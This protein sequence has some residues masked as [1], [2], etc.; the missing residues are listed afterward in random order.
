[1]NPHLLVDELLAV[2]AASRDGVIVGVRAVTR[3]MAWCESQRVQLVASLESFT[4]APELVFAEAAR[5]DARSAVQL[6]ERSATSTVA[7]AFAEALCE[8]RIAVEH[9]DE[10]GRGLRRLEPAD[11]PGLAAQAERLLRIAEQVTPRE[12]AKSVG[13]EVRRL[14]N[15]DGE[16]RLA[17]QQRATRLR[18]WTDRD[19]GMWRIAGSF[20]PATGLRLDS[21]L[22][23]ML[24]AKFAEP[25]P[26]GAPSDPMEK[27]D[28]LRAHAFVDLVTG[29]GVRL[30]RPELTVVV[31]TTT[32]DGPSVDWGLPVELPHRVLLDLFGRA[33]TEVVVIRNG[34]VLHA[35]GQMNLGAST[36]LASRHQRR[37]LRALYPTCAVPGCAVRFDNCKIHHVVWFRNGGRTDLCNLLPLCSKHHHLVHEGGWALRLDADRSLRIDLPDSTVMTTGPPSRR[38]A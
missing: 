5:A 35:P 18:T 4:T 34:V 28:F 19:S 21:A 7:P 8:G 26:P 38:A 2:D 6:A 13:H 1:V 10:F 32:A 22:R 17:R 27:Q 31:D 29:R 36:R 3:L 23:A 37:V 16:A 24:E 20:D 25:P 14:Q 15:D 9:L 12:F 33:D 11:R 30:G